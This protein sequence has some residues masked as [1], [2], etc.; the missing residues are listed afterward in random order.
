MF[1][2]TSYK[3]RK[4]YYF[5][6]IFPEINNDDNC[7]NLIIKRGIFDYSINSITFDIGKSYDLKSNTANNPFKATITCQLMKKNCI[8]NIACFYGNYNGIACSFLIKT[9]IMH[10][11]RIL[12]I[13]QKVYILN[14]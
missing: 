14:L 7:V 10:L 4:L 8:D 13:V 3:I 12:L 11:F 1:F 5:T 9:M 2:D 6:L